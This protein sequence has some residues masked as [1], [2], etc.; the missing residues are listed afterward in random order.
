MKKM[1][2]VGFL[3]ALTM[4]FIVSAAMA[5]TSHVNNGAADTPFTIAVEALGNARDIVLQGTTAAAQ[6]LAVGNVAVSYTLTQD[7]TTQNLLQVSLTNAAFAGGVVYMC[8]PDAAN[9]AKTVRV[10]TGTPAANATQFNFQAA[11]NVASGSYVFLTDYACPVAS[12]NLDADARNLTLRVPANTPTGMAVINMRTVT[13]GNIPVDP[14][15]DANA[16]N[17]AQEFTVELT[18]RNMVIDYLNANGDGPADGSTFVE[19]GSDNVS[20]TRGGALNVWSITHTA[21]DYEA[22]A[23]AGLATAFTTTSDAGTTWTGVAN[24]FLANGGTNCAANLSTVTD[25]PAGAVTIDATYAGGGANVYDYCLTVDGTELAPRTITGTYQVSVTGAGANPT[26]ATSGNYQI[27]TT[28]G[29][30]SYVPNMRWN[31]SN[32]QRTYVRFVN[33]ANRIAEAQVQ[34]FTDEAAPVTYALAS[35]PAYGIVTY[36]A[37]VIAADNG[38]TDTNYGA[39]FTIKTGTDNIFAEAFFN[40]TGYGTRSASLY[41]NNARTLNLK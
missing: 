23:D 28:N 9:A 8:A 16:I 32:S 3:T 38:I 11:A 41:E 30:Q 7:M 22:V 37:G 29:F 33:N 24:A 12:T 1:F 34:V 40:M 31:A 20:V 35:I 18:T 13:A 39:L 17:V 2:G 6:N 25:N 4:I 5:G 36:D 10:G 15:D 27:W 21:M 19:G 26:A 14:D